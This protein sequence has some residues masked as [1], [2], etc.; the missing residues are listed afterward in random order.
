MNTHHF[1]FISSKSFGDFSVDTYAVDARAGSGSFDVIYFVFSTRN[2]RIL[3]GS[4]DLGAVLEYII[5]NL[6]D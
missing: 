5:D 6:M 2:H 4:P 1:G 3:F